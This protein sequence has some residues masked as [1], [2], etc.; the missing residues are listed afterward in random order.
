MKK[1]SRKGKSVS[2]IHQSLR[3]QIVTGALAPGTRL[4]EEQL[5][6]EFGV[7]RTPIREVLRMLDRDRLIRVAQ[8]RGATVVSLSRQEVIDTYQ[9]RGTL[10]GLACR[11]AAERMDS[12]ALARLRQVL[13]ALETAVTKEDI[14]TI[15]ICTVRFNQIVAEVANNIVLVE[16]LNALDDRTL[17]IRFMA[18]TIPERV[19]FALASY[20]GMY[21]AL[22]AGNGQEAEAIAISI[23]H[24][25]MEAILRVYYPQVPDEL[26]QPAV[27]GV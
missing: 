3:M 11:L 22:S 20:Q 13:D 18:H 4:M 5:A 26:A 16:L 2:D 15:F 12:D 8:G 19:R 10:R 27:L 25:A 23:T 21:K 24:N 17:R 6:D 7:S 9:C 14:D 1:A